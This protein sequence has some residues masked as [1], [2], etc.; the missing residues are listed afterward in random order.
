[1]KSK[2]IIL[3]LVVSLGI[4]IGLILW[5]TLPRPSP[6]RIEAYD[7]R[8]GWRKGKLRYRLNLLESQVKAIEAIQETTFGKIWAIRETLTVKRQEL[9]NILRESQPDNF[10]LQQLVKEIADLQTEIE[11][12]LAENILALKKVL[13]PEQQEQ[14]FELFQKRLGHHGEFKINRRP[15]SPKHW[16]YKNWRGPKIKRR[17]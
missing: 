1:M 16:E 9:I 11:L 3:L 8:H 4:N 17:Q 13:T 5:L 7:I 15:F 10:K 2:V 6:R 12:G 14:F